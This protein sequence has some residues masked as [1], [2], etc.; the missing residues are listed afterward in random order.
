MRATH[1]LFVLLLLLLVLGP[2]VE[3]ATIVVAAQDATPEERAAAD[4]RCDGIDDQRDI[5]N[6]FNRLPPE[7]GTVRL[8]PGTFFCPESIFPNERTSLVGAGPS[9]TRIVVHNPQNPYKPISVIVPDVRLRGF[10]L[11]G[12][13]GVMIKES[14]VVVE[15]V[16]ATS[17]GPD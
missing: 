12:S 1:I 17:R 8:T 5:N 9:S 11:M 14:R 15:E 10:T 7:G 13:G 6:A 2:V 16:V 4:I 3:A